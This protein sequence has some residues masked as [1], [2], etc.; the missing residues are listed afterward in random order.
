MQITA[1]DRVRALCCHCGNLRTVS[2]H[3]HHRLDENLTQDAGPNQPNGWRMTCTLKCPGVSG[4][5]GTR[6]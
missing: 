3:H 4:Q 2:A 6:C 1:S 5:L